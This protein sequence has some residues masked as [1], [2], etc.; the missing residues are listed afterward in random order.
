MAFRTGLLVIKIHK[1]VTELE[2]H[3]LMCFCSTLT[4]WNQCNQVRHMEVKPKL[5]RQGG[6][7]EWSGNPEEMVA[8]KKH[9]IKGSST[10]RLHQEKH[11]L[12]NSKGYLEH[13]SILLA[14]DEMNWNSSARKTVRDSR[15]GSFP[16][17][18]LYQLGRTTDMS[19]SISG[20]EFPVKCSLVPS[21]HIKT[22]THF[23][24]DSA[25]K[26]L[27]RVSAEGL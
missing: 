25:W 9:R 16:L 8:E 6:V 24:R 19:P 5:E 15:K 14:I 18:M 20:V 21:I 4:R 26:G 23:N 27:L 13:I 10:S 3:V 2:V 11:L 7:C 12:Q 17:R 1:S 22:L